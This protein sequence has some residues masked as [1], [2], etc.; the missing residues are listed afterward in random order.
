[1]VVI[2]T[3]VITASAKSMAAASTLLLIT[4]QQGR[5]LMK[6]EGFEEWP[7]DIETKQNT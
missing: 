6:Y 1:M 4:H 2:F 5:K 3:P 7:F